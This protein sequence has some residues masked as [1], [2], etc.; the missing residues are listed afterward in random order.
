MRL[1]Y[2]KN[3]RIR[4]SRS[5]KLNLRLNVL[6]IA[7]FIVILFLLDIVTGYSG[8]SF[9][10]GIRLAYHHLFVDS[11]FLPQNT[12]EFQLGLAAIELG[13][14]FILF[15]QIR[16]VLK[17]IISINPPQETGLFFSL[18]LIFLINLILS[19]TNF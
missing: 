12:S 11:P 2:G 14:G 1:Q 8:I 16:Q 19:N 13:I 9:L 3:I 10:P 5:K 7:I 4:K 15:I 18:V 6:T 17:G